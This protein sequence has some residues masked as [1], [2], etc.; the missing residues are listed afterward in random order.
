MCPDGGSVSSAH[1]RTMSQFT[2][3]MEVMC[4]RVLQEDHRFLLRLNAVALSELA[5]PECCA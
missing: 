1:Y 2:D 5:E 4:Q 3:H